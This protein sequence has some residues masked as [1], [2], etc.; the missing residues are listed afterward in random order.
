MIRPSPE[1]LAVYTC[2][3]QVPHL[4][5]SI[6]LFLLRKCMQPEYFSCTTESLN[7][8][9]TFTSSRARTCALSR[10]LPLPLSP[11]PPP[12]LLS[13]AD[14][15]RH[16][17]NPPTF[18]SSL[19]LPMSCIHPSVPFNSH[20]RLNDVSYTHARSGQLTDSENLA[21]SW[22]RQQEVWWSEQVNL[23]EQTVSVCARARACDVSIF[24]SV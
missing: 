6:A 20:L 1:T 19:A 15:P 7:H 24:D 11:S 16:P 23:S 8:T 10:S 2:S 4:A 14:T 22:V 9:Y 12:S 3:F 5:P 21:F 13:H 18:Q 17:L